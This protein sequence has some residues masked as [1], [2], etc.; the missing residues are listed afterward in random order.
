MCNHLFLTLF[1]ISIYVVRASLLWEVWDSLHRPHGQSRGLRDWASSSKD[2]AEEQQG[3]RGGCRAA[4]FTSLCS[5]DPV[6]SLSVDFALPPLNGDPPLPYRNRLS[7]CTDTLST[8]HTPLHR[9]ALWSQ[10]K[11]F[12]K[13]LQNQKSPPFH[14]TQIFQQCE[15]WCMSCS[16]GFIA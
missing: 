7:S 8:E 15:I 9:R 13:I 11:D 16:S 3:R 4:P 6:R 12:P 10:Y 14:P 2:P 1:H 5:C